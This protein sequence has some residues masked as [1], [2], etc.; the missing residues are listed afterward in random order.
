MQESSTATPTLPTSGSKSATVSGPVSSK[1]ERTE[2]LLRL[3]CNRA[4]EP[5][6]VATKILIK[7]LGVD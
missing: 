6:T 3:S 5:S 4:V 7:W 2:A 1:M